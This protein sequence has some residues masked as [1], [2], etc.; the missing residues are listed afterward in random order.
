LNVKKFEDGCKRHSVEEKSDLVLVWC[1]KIMG[2][3]QKNLQLMGEVYKETAQGK[4]ETAKF[5]SGYC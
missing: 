5:T 4:A 1:K 2:V 3:W